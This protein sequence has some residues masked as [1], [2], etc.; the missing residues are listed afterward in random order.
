MAIMHIRG[1]LRVAVVVAAL[2]LIAVSAA[3]DGG[4]TP[5]S[6][7]DTWLSATSRDQRNRPIIHSLRSA[8]L[9]LTNRARYR[10]RIGISW[11]FRHAQEN[12]MPGREDRA[13]M[14]AID[15]AIQ[16]DFQRNDEHRIVYFSTGGNVREVMLYG[17]SEATAWKR[18]EALFRQF[19]D[20]FPGD[21]GRWAYV[22]ADAD[23][24]MYRAV[25]AMLHPPP[26]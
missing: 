10:W 14:S 8:A 18:I 2:V 22:K 9:Q 21:R 12:G 6:E 3:A 4:I 16:R 25:A 11:R 17:V 19:P 1:A 24:T 15:D 20:E 7:G 26:K 13:P 5:G 23:W